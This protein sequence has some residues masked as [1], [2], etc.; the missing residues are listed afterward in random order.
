MHCLIGVGSR[1]YDP[2][3]SF[4]FN[5]L[6]SF[7]FIYRSPT[8]N[9]QRD[10]RWGRNQEV[11]G[12]DPFLTGQYSKAFVQA[13]QGSSFRDGDGDG[14]K[15]EGFDA[16]DGDKDSS[17]LKMGACC[18]HFLGNSLEHWGEYDRYTFDAHIDQED[19]NNYYLPPFEECTKHAVGVM[20][21]YNAVNGEPTCA[22]NWLLKDVLR[23]RMNFTGYIVTD[24]GA[25]NGVVHGHHFAIDNVQASA[26]VKNAS[27]DVNCGSVFQ[28]SLPK[29]YSEGQ[30]EEVTINES[31][32]RMARIQ[33]RLGL[34]D[35]TKKEKNNPEIDIASIDSTQHQQLTLEAALQ[36]IVLLENKNN[37]LPLDMNEKKSL[38][39]IGPHIDAQSALMGNYHGAR[40]GCPTDRGINENFDCIESPLQAIKRKMKFSDEVKSIKGCNIAD[41]DIMDIDKATELAENADSVI[42]FLG[43]DQSQESEGRDRIETTLPGLQ[44]KLMESVLDIAGDKTIIVLIHGGTVSL[45]EGRSKAG[46][47]ISTGYGG[48]TGA[49]AIAS[50]L[51]GEFNPTGKLA[52]TVYPP[53]FVH[54]LP[55]TEMGLRVGVGRTYMYYTGKAEY[56]FGHGLSYSR[57]KLDWVNDAGDNVVSDRSDTLPTLNLYES[58]STR[59]R[60]SVKNLG[61][62]ITGSSQ[63]LLLFWRPTKIIEKEETRGFAPV[64]KGEKRKIR[65]KLID[66]Q[67]SSLLRVGQSEMLEFHLH[68]KDF[69]LWDSNSNAF[70]VLPGSYELVIQVADIYLI[71]RLEVTPS[72]TQEKLARLGH[73]ESI[74]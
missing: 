28:K 38:A 1:V 23:G 20:C 22:S 9:M 32:N 21:S 55:L 36:S 26:M 35:S 65:Q 54:E 63:T 29:A 42:L 51:F 34:F 60:V 71:R 52:A 66:F 11:P 27:V 62:H 30:V 57:W 15:L 47:I 64:N 49:F 6:L 56:T 45:G 41:N 46:A 69:T 72:N 61:P 8:I 2:N 24:C 7:Y 19:L 48:Q 44:I 14:D 18:K 43:L 31:F 39:V 68:W 33:F 70:I 25:L 12:E 4:S 37:L 50:V 40:C 10:P 58:A 3:S 13:L 17:Y 16:D 74:S 53:S 67:E 73:P 5:T 59:F